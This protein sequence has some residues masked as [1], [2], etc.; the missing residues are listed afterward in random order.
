MA[1]YEDLSTE[2][3]H[4]R[5]FRAPAMRSLPDAI[6]TGLVAFLMACWMAG[7]YAGIVYWSL[8]GSLLGVILS[9]VVPGVAAPATWWLFVEFRGY[10]RRD[11]EDVARS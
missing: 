3:P 1:V 8:H 5:W 4:G 10:R 11:A 2:R 6:R 9:A 7:A